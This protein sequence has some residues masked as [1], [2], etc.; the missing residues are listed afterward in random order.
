MKDIAS[1]IRR[2]ADDGHERVV[3]IRRALHRRPELAFEEHETAAR[4]ADELTATG[5]DRMR[6]G[7]A[8]TGVVAE[9][10]GAAGPAERLVILRADIDALPIRE[11]NT[12]D[13]ASEVDG[14]M[15]ACGHDA[16]TASLLGAARILCAIRDR[17]SGTVRLLFQPSEEKLP[18]GAP[19]MIAEGALDVADGQA[20]VGIFGQ[21]VRPGIAAGKLGVRPGAFMASADEIYIT[22]S[23]Q[24]GHAAEPHLQDADAVYVASQ[25]VVALQSVVSRNRPPREPSVLTIGRFVADGATNVI[26][27]VVKLEGTLRAMNEAWRREAHDLI[28]RVVAGTAAAFGAQADVDIRIGYP[29]LVNDAEASALVDRA[30]R[31]YIGD[32]DVVALDPWYAAEDF[33]FYLEHVPGAFYMLGVRNEADGI[34]H[35]VHTPRFTVDESALRTGAGFLAYLAVRALNLR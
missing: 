26:P 8:S 22:V 1:D 23:A 16:H 24:G 5:V 33:A 31:E 30:A 7:V 4:V 19:A 2:L 27:P 17:F 21:H 11:E 25:I 13:F 32:P 3:E 29:A 10:D 14:K 15:H 34:T 18:G 28:R 9:I 12:F 20:L 6:T 35:A